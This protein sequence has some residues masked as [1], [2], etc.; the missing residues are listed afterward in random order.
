M[1]RA[2]QSKKRT[3]QLGVFTACAGVPVRLLTLAIFVCT[4]FFLFDQLR[5]LSPDSQQNILNM[6]QSL[7]YSNLGGLNVSAEDPVTR[8]TQESSDWEP[9]VRIAYLLSAHDTSTILGVLELIELLY[10]PK[11]IF[12]VHLDKKILDAE[13]ANFTL[14][15]SKKPNI[16]MVKRMNVE[17]AGLTQVDM[18]LKSLKRAEESGMDYGVAVNLCGASFPIKT[19]REI[20]Q[21]LREKIISQKGHVFSFSSSLP[22]CHPKTPFDVCTRTSARCTDAA[23]TSMDLTPEHRLMYKGSSWFQ[24]GRE[25]VRY[26]LNSDEARQWY[27]FLKTGSFIDEVFFHSV[28]K[29]SIFN[30]SIIVDTC[31]YTDWRLPCK[32]HVNP[33]PILSPCPLGVNDFDTLVAV[34]QLFARKIKADDPLR[35]KLRNFL[36]AKNQNQQSIE[37]DS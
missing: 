16:V 24:I 29:N 25:L 35:M 4:A 7:L 31:M 21:Y 5:I 36:N 30:T 2:Q 23:C 18:L 10:H 37:S 6:S 26:F 32:T 28:A 8:K 34:P 13:Y 12:A 20:D 19:N 17:W 22:I 11:H 3:R 14:Q 1:E 9:T 33:R 27:E 15:V